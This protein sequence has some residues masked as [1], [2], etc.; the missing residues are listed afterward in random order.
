MN[1]AGGALY[2]APFI[3]IGHND[4]LAWT[5]TVATAWRFA[6]FE[7]RLAPGDPYSYV[8]DGQT[9]PMEK[10]TVT[11]QVRNADG[12]IGERTGTTYSTDYGPVL[13][14]ILGLPIFPWTPERAYALGDA[15]GENFRYLNH[16]VR[17]QQAGSVGEYDRIQREIQGIP[18][19]NSIAADRRGTSYYSMDGSVPN[20]TDEKAAEC[21]APIGVALAAAT[22]IPVLD[23]SR[24][25]CALATDPDAAAPGILGPNKLPHLFRRDYVTNGNDSHWLTN[26]EQPLEGFDRIVGDERTER[27]LRT[28]LGLVMVEDR[29][30]GTDG[31]PGKGFSLRDLQTVAI[32]NRQYAGELWRDELV[33]F[34]K[35]SPVLAGTAGPVA[36]AD[37]CPV[38][39]AYN[40]H[41]DL[42][43]KGAVL[44]RRFVANVIAGQTVPTGTA[45]SQNPFLD[46]AMEVP[47]DASD[48]VHTPRGLSEGSP[49]VGRALA[50]AIN[51]LRGAG[52]PLDAPLGD[53]QYDVLGGERIPIHG[54]PGPLGIFNAITSTWNPKEGY[55]NIPHGTSFLTAVAFTDGKCPA[56]A[57][58]FVT[59]GQSENLRSPHAND[60]T[61]A[62]S[63]KD[64]NAVP[65]CGKQLRRKTLEIERLHAGG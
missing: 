58:T 45:S 35:A 26:P 56:K 61:K 63:A 33:A 15:N 30:N 42:D 43:S 22:G 37:A 14:S 3:A 47:F 53:W 46:L 65:Y 5:H 57:R 18:W 49:L 9:K 60:Y 12:T 1:A 19:V 55:S 38:L 59:Y 62:F 23:G 29:L 44:F 8:V 7:L 27:S 11:I 10:H 54:G 36:T 4:S 31:L 21:S 64:W 13:T 28:R 2:G 25:A 39:E 16:F 17:T 52:I 34:C 51:D 6:P 40:L 32:N 48:P 20:V 41:D 24:S 50:D